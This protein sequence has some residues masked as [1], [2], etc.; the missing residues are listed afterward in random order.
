MKLAQPPSPPKKGSPS[1][2]NQAIFVRKR[3]E[4][5]LV[6]ATNLLFYSIFNFTNDLKNISI[7]SFFK[8][9]AN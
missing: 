7:F 1:G 9:I 5:R 8:K 4:L 2:Y 3:F 6:I